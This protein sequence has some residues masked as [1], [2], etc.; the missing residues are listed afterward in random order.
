V[1][2]YAI[3]VVYPDAQAWTVPNE[4][5]GCSAAEGPTNYGALT[6]AT[7]PRPILYS[8]GTRAVVEVVPAS[9]PNACTGA[10][11]VPDV[12]LPH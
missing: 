3:N 4:A 7:Q 2:R 5:G 11:K 8:Q 1:G 12:C 10:M 6:C 9:D